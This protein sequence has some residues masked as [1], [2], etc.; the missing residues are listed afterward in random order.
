MQVLGE[1][2]VSIPL[3]GSHSIYVFNIKHNHLH[4]LSCKL[5]MQFPSAQL[6]CGTNPGRGWSM[7]LAVIEPSEIALSIIRKPLPRCVR[8]HVQHCNPAG[9]LRKTSDLCMN[10]LVNAV[11]K[12]A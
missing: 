2:V 9:G 11:H 4:N 12:Q 8:L 7:G 3:S 6:V 5:S 1:R 10:I